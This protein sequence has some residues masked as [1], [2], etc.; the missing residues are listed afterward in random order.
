MSTA[1]CI[2]LSQKQTRPRGHCVKDL[3][4]QM[5]I[6]ANEICQF[7][8]HGKESLLRAQQILLDKGLFDSR[9]VDEAYKRYDPATYRARAAVAWGVLQ[10]AS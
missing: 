5:R 3:Y 4:D 9:S 8:K 2:H 6:S 7:D 1:V 10:L